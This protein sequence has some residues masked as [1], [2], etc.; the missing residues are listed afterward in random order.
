M[1]AIA[2][3]GFELWNVFVMTAVSAASLRGRPPMGVWAYIKILVKKA[4]TFREEMNCEKHIYIV[5]L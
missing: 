3:W 2:F 1:I 4:P 5:M